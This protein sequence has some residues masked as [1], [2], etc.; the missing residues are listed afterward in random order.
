MTRF[1]NE[2]KVNLASCFRGLG[3]FV[4]ELLTCGVVVIS[5]EGYGFVVLNL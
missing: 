1:M 4:D 3:L 2:R 5:G